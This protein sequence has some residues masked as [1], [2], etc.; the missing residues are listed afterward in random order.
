M[1]KSLGQ[2]EGERAKRQQTE[3]ARQELAEQL[4]TWNDSGYTIERLREMAA[5]QEKTEIETA[6]AKGDVE[7]LL[8]NRDAKHA[9]DLEKRDE[10]RASVEAKYESE[11][12]LN[13]RLLID[14]EMNAELSKIVEP[15]LMDGA[16]ALLRPKA[17]A[18][19][20]ADSPYG[21]RVVMTVGDDE[22]PVKDFLKQWAEAD[23]KAQ[24]Y[25]LG[26]R[27]QGGGAPPAGGRPGANG[28]RMKRSQMTPTQKVEYMNTYGVDQYERLPI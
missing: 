9:R 22:M 26:N 16:F 25:L 1:R 21:R 20:D 18:V 24:A 7:K 23:P 10:I 8:A 5:E 12:Q 13:D 19:E 17:K 28:P 2:Y 11:R 14:A 6:K 15:L 4:K 3:K 27:S